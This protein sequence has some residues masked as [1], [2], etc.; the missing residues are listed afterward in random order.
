MPVE[1]VQ[2]DNEI[3][4]V[5]LEDGKV[6]E[7]ASVSDTEP[8]ISVQKDTENVQVELEDGN[9]MDKSVSA[10]ISCGEMKSDDSAFLTA[11]DMQGTSLAMDIRTD[12]DNLMDELHDGSFKTSEP[13]EEAEEDEE[14]EDDEESHSSARSSED[15]VE[16]EEDDDT[17]MAV[18]ILPS[19]DLGQTIEI[20]DDDDEEQEPESDNQKEDDEFE[21][22]SENN[23]STSDASQ[24]SSSAEADEENEEQDED[25]GGVVETEPIKI[26]IPAETTKLVSKFKKTKTPRQKLK[27]R[28][29]KL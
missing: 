27:A 1:S 5:E 15:D 13:L 2:K 19:A 29:I 16:D 23:Q 18:K 9:L 11:D 8:L 12:D 7:T 21:E 26:T 6:K 28:S 20:D 4:D 25:F 10:N 3:V 17:E 22:E 14:I 24:N